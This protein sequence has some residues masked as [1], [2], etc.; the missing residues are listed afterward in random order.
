MTVTLETGDMVC[1]YKVIEL[2]GEGG[3]SQLY[4]ATAADGSVVK[5]K[6]PSLALIGDPATYERFLRE[7]SIG[8]KMSHPAIQR[9]IAMDESSDGIFIVLEYIQGE[10]LRAFFNEKAP[11]A[12]EKALYIFT[13]LAEAVEY[14]H[15]NGVYHRDLKPENILIGPDDRIHIVDFGIALLEGARRV[16][17]GMA[18]D[19]FGT[20][21]YMAPEQI[22]GKRG[23]ARTDI[24]ALGI[25]FYEMATGNVPFRGDNSLS[26]MSQHMTATPPAPSKVNPSIPPGIEA[27]ILKSIRRNPDQ[28]YQNATDLIQDLKNY[29]KLDLTSFNVQPEKPAR[30]VMTDRQIWTMGAIIG[31]SFLAIAVLIIVIVFLVNRH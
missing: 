5:L 27:I 28:R 1:G 10:S 31:G 4:K 29:D 6:F 11:L 20:P 30:G 2:I 15:K 18:T 8:Q 16:T 17:W 25:I 13:Q 14:L 3:L 12:M 9:T 26:I 19:A 21:D 24:Y 23:D 7:F 22:Q